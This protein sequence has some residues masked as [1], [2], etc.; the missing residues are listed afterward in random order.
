MTPE[1]LSELKSKVSAA[2]ISVETALDTLYQAAQDHV[3]SAAAG[4]QTALE[5]A[6]SGVTEVIAAELAP[7]DPL[8]D[9]TQTPAQLELGNGD[10]I[11]AEP[12]APAADPVPAELIA[13]LVPPV[14]DSTPVADQ[15][16]N[17]VPPVDPSV[18]DGVG[19]DPTL[20]PP[21]IDSKSVADPVDGPSD[22][23]AVVA[24]DAPNTP[25]GLA[26]AKLAALKQHELDDIKADD[27]AIAEAQA[28]VDRLSVPPS[29]PAV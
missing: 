13:D 12:D 15:A 29:E 14:P 26:V 3:A 9:P 11:H 7:L 1:L 8:A 17:P 2:L 27:A 21:D 10:Q 22:P 28:E 23:A 25:L 24:P 6:A 20:P 19:G 18:P 5:S 4:V 16:V